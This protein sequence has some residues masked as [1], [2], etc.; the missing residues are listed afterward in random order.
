[1][2]NSCNYST[3]KFEAG[4]FLQVQGRPGLCNWLQM[5]IQGYKMSPVPEALGPGSSS[6][7]SMLVGLFRALS[8]TPACPKPGMVVHTSTAVLSRRRQEDQK[9]KVILIYMVSLRL[10]WKEGRKE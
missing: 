8:L 5:T 3:Q 2:A 6:V 1:M 4:G 10:A 7:H 9:S